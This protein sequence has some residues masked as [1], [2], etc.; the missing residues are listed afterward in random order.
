MSERKRV[1]QAAEAALPG[2]ALAPVV[3]VSSPMLFLQAGEP[4]P[5]TRAIN[6]ASR[7]KKLVKRITSSRSSAVNAP[8]KP[9]PVLRVLDH[10]GKVIG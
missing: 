10:N 1:W 9:L 6:R 3:G 7:K 5:R 4:L 8:P 2:L